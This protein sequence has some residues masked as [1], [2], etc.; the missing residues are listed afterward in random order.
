LVAC[1]VGGILSTVPSLSDVHITN[2]IRVFI[3]L[4]ISILLLP[5]IGNA[6]IIPQSDINPDMILYYMMSESIIGLAI[7][8]VAGLYYYSLHVLG[9]IIGMQSGMSAATIFDPNQRESTALFSN[10]LLVMCS[11]Y[12]FASDTHHVFI[13][14]IID[15]YYY[16]PFAQSLDYLGDIANRLAEVVQASFTLAFKIS[17]PFLIVNIAIMCASSILS[18]LMPSLQILFI[19]TPGQILCSFMVLYIVINDILEATINHITSYGL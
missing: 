17:S 12:I 16:F 5:T 7:G 15:S 3:I 14:G 13:S 8:L 18:R 1:R 4:F 9:S 2:S 10:M 6:S 19:I 11:A